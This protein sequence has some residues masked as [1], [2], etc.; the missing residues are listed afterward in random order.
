MSIRLCLTA[1]LATLLLAQPTNAA[2]PAF[3]TTLGGKWTGKG[4][5]RVNTKA[6]AVSVSCSFAAKSSTVTLTLD[7]N[8]R[9]MVLISRSIGVRLKADGQRYGGTYIGSR[10]GPAALSGQRRGDVL[11]LGIRWAKPVNGD[12]NAEMRVEKIG[13]NAMRIVT[14]D[15][16]ATTGKS[17]VT[18]Q[19]DLKRN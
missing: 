13:Q 1:A 6:P 12:R 9:G 14:I 19:V 4:S 8:C 18:A 17:V 3:L 7:G 16:D 2:E 15:K 11:N 10:T 5:F